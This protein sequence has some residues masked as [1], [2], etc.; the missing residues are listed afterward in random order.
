MST[1]KDADK[2]LQMV[3]ECFASKPIIKKVPPSWNIF[4]ENY[5]KN[6]RVNTTKH[7]KQIDKNLDVGKTTDNFEK[8]LVFTNGTSV[9]KDNE[10]VSAALKFIFVYPVKS[11]GAYSVKNSWEIESTGLIY[12]RQWMIVSSSGVCL[13]QKQ[14]PKLCLITPYINIK[15][16]VLELNYPGTFMS[17]L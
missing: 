8:Q 17:T 15:D 9:L 6:F 10:E 3:E 5:Y 7:V 4:E 11:C 2:F 1:K 16:G 13:T 12:D 14:N